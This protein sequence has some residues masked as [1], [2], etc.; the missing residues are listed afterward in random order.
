MET[1]SDQESYE[2]YQEIQEEK[3]ESLCRRCG[4]CCGIT[5][6]DPCEHLYQTKAGGY[7]CRI[8]HNRFGEHK[9]TSGKT[10][11]CV[12]IRDILQISWPGD[13]CCGYKRLKLISEG[14]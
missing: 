11:R 3:W 10:F 8:Y 9:T 14:R 5:E 12:P 4:A 1:I 6:G 13:Q 2:R 7:S